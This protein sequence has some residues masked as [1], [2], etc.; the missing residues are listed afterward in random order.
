M[1]LGT[2]NAFAPIVVET[3]QSPERIHAF[4]NFLLH[5]QILNAKCFNPQRGFMLLGTPVGTWVNITFL[6]FQ[7]PERIHAFGN[8]MDGRLWSRGVRFQ[9]PERIHAFGN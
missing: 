1:L 9:S 4:G 3:F 8:L 2:T 7:S 5:H 6:K